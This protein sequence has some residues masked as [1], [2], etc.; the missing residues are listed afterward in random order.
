[1]SEKVELETT[2]SEDL[3]GSRLDQALAELFPEH[4]RS[5]LQTWIKNGFVTVNGTV[6]QRP[7]D[8]VSGGEEIIIKAELE[9]Q[10]TWEAQEIPL[11][12]VY[13]D[14]HIIVINKPIGL[15]VHPATGNPDKTL[16]N[17]LL[18]LFPELDKLPR[19]GIVHR[20][21]KDTSGIMV[22]A[23]SPEA[24][25]SLVNQLQ[26]RT[27]HREYEAVVNGVMTAG[28]TVDA[29]MGRHPTQRVRMAVIEN[30]TGKLAVT[31]YRVLDRFRAHT[32]IRV[33][34]ETG[35]THQ[36]RVHMAHIKYPLVGDQVYAGRLKIPKG[37]SDKLIET[38]RSFKHQALHARRLEL[39]HPA[40]KEHMEWSV[41]LPK[42]MRELLKVLREDKKM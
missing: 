4:S 29:P 16:V 10:A 15:V 3:A 24:H 28:G 33:Q 38:L 7:R 19:A 11:D 23:R 36:I 17:A 6:H 22:V 18:H 31:H 25:T 30:G 13:Q 5:R 12:I 42:D 32:H 2:I 39:E 21:D 27:M 40:T 34:L 8:K 20:L 1:M 35:R 14:E 9:V 26:E 37:S 41:E